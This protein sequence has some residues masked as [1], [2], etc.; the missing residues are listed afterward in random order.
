MSAGAATRSDAGLI[1]T[2]LDDTCLNFGDRFQAYVE[3]RG[4][5][6]TGRLR[7]I[8]RIEDLLGITTE[9]VIPH[10]EAFTGDPDVRHEPEPCAQAV[11]PILRGHGYRFVGISACGTDPGYHARRVANLTE[12]FGFAF[13]ALICVPFA[14]SKREILAR[15]RDAVWVEDN[16]AHAETG[17]ALGHRT[18]LIDRPYNSWAV[19]SARPESAAERPGEESEGT[20]PV[21]IA[22]VATWWD[23][24]GAL[25]PKTLADITRSA[26]SRGVKLDL[27]AYTTP[28]GG[29][30]RL[31]WIENQYQRKGAG[32]AALAD[33]CAYAD[34]RTSRI[35]LNVMDGEPALIALYAEHGFTMV[36]PHDDEGPLMVREPR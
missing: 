18:F 7:D 33:L 20:Q 23:I 15:Y 1:L 17:A 12:A 8:W 34:G 31:D 26:E 22:R 28:E 32:R 29:E 11:F 24:L 2:D 19:R 6:T 35:L 4:L 25:R 30:I 16:L 3:A 36:D 13:D 9:E 5:R 10:L 21:P 14:G 27:R